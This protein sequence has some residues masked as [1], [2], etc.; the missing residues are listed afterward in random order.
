MQTHWPKKS[1]MKTQL[2]SRHLP[3]NASLWNL[4]RSYLI[5]ILKTTNLQSQIYSAQTLKLKMWNIL[6]CIVIEH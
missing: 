1:S 4:I 5:T 6:M 3:S 2:L